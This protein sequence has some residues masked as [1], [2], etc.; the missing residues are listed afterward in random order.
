MCTCVLPR[1][2]Q[3]LED[4]VGVGDGDILTHKLGLPAS[5]EIHRDTIQEIPHQTH[6]IRRIIPVRDENV[7]QPRLP[8]LNPNIT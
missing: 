2:K 1:N 6:P 8:R 7:D 3:G 4:R 5:L